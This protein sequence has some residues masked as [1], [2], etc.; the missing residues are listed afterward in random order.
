V[1][2]KRGGGER[3]KVKDGR[4]RANG[5]ALAFGTVDRGLINRLS[6]GK[7]PVTDVSNASRTLM[8]D[9]R[10][11]KGDEEILKKLRVPAALLPAVKSSSEV[12]A[13]T[14]PELFGAPIPIAGCPGDQ[15]A[16]PFGQDSFRPAMMKNHSGT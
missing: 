13:E 8:Y 14:A 7:T 10:R 5:G 11:Q 6:G 2:G 12:Y 9:I 3:E 16:A 1:A 15:Q 4:K